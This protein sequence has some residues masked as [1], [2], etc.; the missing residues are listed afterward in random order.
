MTHED[1]AFIDA[2]ME[3]LAYTSRAQVTACVMR[4]KARERLETMV[5]DIPNCLSIIDAMLMWNS[6]IQFVT[7]Q[8]ETA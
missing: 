1:K 5:Q 2:Y 7:K 4:F 6:A 8:G 3:N